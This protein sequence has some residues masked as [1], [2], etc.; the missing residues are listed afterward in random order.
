MIMHIHNGCMWPIADDLR[1][2]RKGR[3]FEVNGKSRGS[4]AMIGS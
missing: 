3:L 4:P 2:N 1:N